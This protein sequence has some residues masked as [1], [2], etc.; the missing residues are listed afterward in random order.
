[1]SGAIL[2]VGEPGI[3]KT[4]LL[5]YAAAG[6]SGF[7]VLRARGVQSEAE[8]AFAALLEICRPILGAVDRLEPPQAEALAGALGLSDVEGATRFT[9]GAATLALLAAAA[10]EC[11][12]LLLVDDAH[13]LDRAS[14]DALAFAIRRLHMD[15]VAALFA[16]R[17]GEGRPFSGH[18]LPELELERLDLASAAELLAALRS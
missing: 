11:S 8:L 4:A 5:D 7:R 15:S 1:M 3:G 12:L 16:M 10:E 2:L 18:Q 9:I 13:W 17:P 6:A 14:A